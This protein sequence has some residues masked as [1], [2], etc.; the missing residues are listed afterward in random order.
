MDDVEQKDNWGLATTIAEYMLG[1]DE[2]DNDL[3]ISIYEWLDSPEADVR[4]GDDI[5]SLATRYE[6][7]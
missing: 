3:Y 2:W 4:E 6:L 5:I 7:R 1:D